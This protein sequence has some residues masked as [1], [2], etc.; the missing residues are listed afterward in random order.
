VGVGE[1]EVEGES[2]DAEEDEECDRT[3][4]EEAP[5]MVSA[6][7]DLLRDEGGVV[8]AFD[9]YDGYFGFLLWIHSVI[10]RIIVL[11]ELL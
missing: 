5:P 4:D 7:V 9:R 10:H 11:R 6:W 3:E 1:I 2:R 8:I